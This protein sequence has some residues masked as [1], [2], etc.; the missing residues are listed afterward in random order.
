LASKIEKD[1]NP[2][3][4]DKRNEEEG[5]FEGSEKGPDGIII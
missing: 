4:P 1:V 5:T 2:D 3:G